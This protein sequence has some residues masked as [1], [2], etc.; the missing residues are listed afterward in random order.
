MNTWF[1]RAAKA[2]GSTLRGAASR[3]LSEYFYG[4]HSHLQVSQRACGQSSEVLPPPATPAVGSH[5][6]ICVPCVL[7]SSPPKLA[8]E[9][10]CIFIST[11]K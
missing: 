10:L 2:A 11:Y 5:T 4:G 9:L 1:S 3:D 6:F 8:E 7:A